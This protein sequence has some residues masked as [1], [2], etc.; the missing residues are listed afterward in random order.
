MPKSVHLHWRA[1]AR[2]QMVHEATKTY[3]NRKMSMRISGAWL[4]TLSLACCLCACVPAAGQQAD[5]QRL[6]GHHETFS[7]QNIQSH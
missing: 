4:F 5:V 6:F 2:R 1:F 7:K 3:R